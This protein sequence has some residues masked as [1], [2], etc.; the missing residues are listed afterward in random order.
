MNFLAVLDG[1]GVYGSLLHYSFVVA[2]VGSAFLIFICIWWKGK[3]NMDEGP[4]FQMMQEEEIA[5]EKNDDP[6]IKGK[7]L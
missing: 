3:L 6:N 5:K 2:F 7:A 4:K 1:A